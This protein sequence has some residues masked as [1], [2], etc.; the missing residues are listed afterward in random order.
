MI[1]K[2]IDGIKN[3]F[4]FTI[5]LLV[6]FLLINFMTTFTNL[7]KP[8]ILNEAGFVSALNDEKEY[9][10]AESSNLATNKVNN[11]LSNLELVGLYL[12]GFLFIY[13]VISYMRF[14]FVKMLQKNVKRKK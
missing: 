10:M 6:P 1:E 14:K 11:N 7:S 9:N 3:I 8:E 5:I 2:F 12:L 13:S 4:T